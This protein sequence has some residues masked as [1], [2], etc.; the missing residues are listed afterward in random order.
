ME[1][2]LPE[3]V[4]STQILME[5]GNE[6]NG[7]RFPFFV[8]PKVLEQLKAFEVRKG[9]V[10][11]ATYPKCGT[12]WMREIILLTQQDGHVDKIKRD[13]DPAVQGGLSFTMSPDFKYSVAEALANQ[14]SPRMCLTHLP[15]KLLPP[16][17]WIKK[18]KLVYLTRNPKDACSSAYRFINAFRI[19]NGPL[20]WDMFFKYF[21][22]KKVWFG[23]WSDHALSYWEHRNDGHVFFVTFEEMKQDIRSVVRRLAQFL[24]ISITPEGLERIIKHSSL[25]GMR[26]TFAQ[27]EEE[28]EN[29]KFYTRAFGEVPFIQKGVI[30]SWRAE[31]TEKQREKIDTTVKEKLAGTGLNAYY[32]L[33]GSRL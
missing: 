20:P 31:F 12:H 23:P 1:E 26:R 25:K 17:V 33:L 6:Y 32:N 13:L 2:D 28:N 29:G 30:G 15:A 8:Q 16:E 27:I 4:S 5:R 19:N 9:D 22:S 3:I 14:P 11:L 21:T 24:E 10:I 7:I 18:P